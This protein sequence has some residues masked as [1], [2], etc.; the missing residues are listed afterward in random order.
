MNINKIIGEASE[1]IT[2]KIEEYIKLH[3]RK[4]PQ[5]LPYFIWKKILQRLIIIERFK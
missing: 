1:N 4:R 3:I 2:L 5:W